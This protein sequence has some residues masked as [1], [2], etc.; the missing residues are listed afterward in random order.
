MMTRIIIVFVKL[1]LRTWKVE[2]LV[3]IRDCISLGKG[4]K[5]ALV[6]ISSADHYQW[7]W[8]KLFARANFRELPMLTRFGW[9]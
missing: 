4:W 2:T 5:N 1:K 9:Y 8:L 6:T 7:T 3:G